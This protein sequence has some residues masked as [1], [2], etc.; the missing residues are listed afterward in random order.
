[1]DIVTYETGKSKKNRF[2]VKYWGKLQ[3]IYHTR[4]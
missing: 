2:F 3:F 4:T 1:M